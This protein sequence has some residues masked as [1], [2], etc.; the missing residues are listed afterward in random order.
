MTSTPED[1]STVEDDDG[2]SEET[3]VSGYGSSPG[4]ASGTVRI[5]ES[6]DELDK[7]GDGEVIVTAMTTP[8]MVSAVKRAAAVVTDEGGMTSH[9]A[10]ISREL[11]VPAVVGADDAT[12]KLHDGGTVTV[13]GDKGRVT[14]SAAEAEQSRESSSRRSRGR[15][16]GALITAT[17]VMVNVSIPEAAERAAATGADGVGLLRLEHILLSANKTPDRYVEDHGEEAYIEMLADGIRTVADAFHPRPVRVRTLD[18]PTNELAELVGGENEPVEHNPMLGYRGIRRSLAEPEICK[19]ELRAFGNLYEMGYDNVEIMFPMA[20]D[21]D[22]LERARGLMTEVDINPKKRTWGAMIETPGSVRNIEEIAETGIDF[23][24]FGTNDLIQFMLAVDRDNG[25]IADRFDA[26]HPTH[27]EALSDCIG[28]CRERDVETCIVGQAASRPEMV[29][30]LV[31]EGITA[32][33]ANVDAVDDMRQ[34]V[35]RAERRLR[36]D[37]ARERLREQEGRTRLPTRKRS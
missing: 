8:D 23:T 28:A 30:F 24:A 25:R 10:I 33:S 37:K 2:T 15:T 21:A 14:A 13:D 17:N 11:G 27:L 19:L 35:S 32:V 20:N 22:E 9:A 29:R 34:E 4:V 12:E 3:L 1:G 18:A 26:M 6:L 7:V 36:L 5:V 16:S 31:E